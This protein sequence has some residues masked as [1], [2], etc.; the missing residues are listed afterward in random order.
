MKGTSEDIIKALR[1]EAAEWEHCENHSEC[2]E[3]PFYQDVYSVKI[4]NISQKLLA[5]AA[6]LL[7]HIIDMH[8]Q[9]YEEVN[10]LRSRMQATVQ[11]NFR[12]HIKNRFE[13]KE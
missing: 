8:Q 13:K 1:C 5:D 3:C 4:S 6:E 7:E 2:K 11:D 12:N 9:K 10:R